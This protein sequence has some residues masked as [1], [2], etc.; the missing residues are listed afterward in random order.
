MLK[1]GIHGV[2]IKECLMKK[3]TEYTIDEL[4]NPTK[5]FVKV[6]QGIFQLNMSSHAKILFMVLIGFKNNNSSGVHPSLSYLAKQINVKCR[7]SVMRCLKELRE[8]GLIEWEQLAHNGANHY[9][10]D[11]SNIVRLRKKRTMGKKT[12]RSR[13]KSPTYKDIK[14]LR[15]NI[16]EFKK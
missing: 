8:L 11:S 5:H 10:F 14:L 1:V 3:K 2:L 15:N 7:K 13:V 9:Y 16:I 6:S 4:L 12:Q